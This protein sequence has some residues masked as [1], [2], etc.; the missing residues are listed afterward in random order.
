M[1]RYNPEYSAD[2]KPDI[3]KSPAAYAAFQKQDLQRGF[4]L[5]ARFG[6]TGAGIVSVTFGLNAV[7]AY[8]VRLPELWLDENGRIVLNVSRP[9]AWVGT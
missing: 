4:G 3:T 5:D 8:K 2:R 1:G 7:F 9:Y 6:T